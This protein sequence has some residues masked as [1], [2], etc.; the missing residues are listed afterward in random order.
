MHVFEIITHTSDS[1]AMGR[2]SEAY[3]TVCV[4]LS[5]T[6]WCLCSKGKRLELSTPNLVRHTVHGSCTACIDPEAKRSKVKL[7][8]VLSA[9]IC[10]SVVTIYNL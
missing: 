6:V 2:A 9:L 1:L 4:C 8:S 5:D 10:I 7:T 3:V